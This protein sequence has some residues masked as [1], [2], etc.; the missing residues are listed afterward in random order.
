MMMIKEVLHT[1]VFFSINVT[2]NV[3]SVQQCCSLVIKWCCFE[4]KGL[5]GPPCQTSK[6][7]LQPLT[8]CLAT[9]LQC[10]SFIT[11]GEETEK[12]LPPVCSRLMASSHPR[13]SHWLE[14][15]GTFLDIVTCREF[16]W[17]CKV[18][19]RSTLGHG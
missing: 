16:V 11:V 15:K 18:S 4:K 12:M 1:K 3:T 8:L 17:S 14:T 2:L 10:C 6:I 7:T 5:L 19:E 13:Q 9:Q